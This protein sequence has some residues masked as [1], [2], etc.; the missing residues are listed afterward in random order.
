METLE[1][2]RGVG[3]GEAN[4]LARVH[5]DA[6]WFVFLIL[7]SKIFHDN[8]EKTKTMGSLTPQGRHLL[9]FAPPCSS[10]RCPGSTHDFPTGQ[11]PGPCST[12]T[13]A[14]S[15]CE[16]QQQREKSVRQAEKENR[17]RKSPNRVS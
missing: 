5:S 9:S 8:F 15:V 13:R 2:S 3:T 14:P 12:Q 17:P 10:Q 7:P 16:P 11:V 4:T 1:R 6:G